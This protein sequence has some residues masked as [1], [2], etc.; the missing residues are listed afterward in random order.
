M[1]AILRWCNASLESKHVHWP[2]LQRSADL[3]QPTDLAVTYAM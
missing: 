1:F 3:Q 2:P